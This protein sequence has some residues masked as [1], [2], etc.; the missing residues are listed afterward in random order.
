MFNK[1]LMTATLGLA[2]LAPNVTPA[3][4]QN[5]KR[6]EI[7]ILS[8][9]D[10]DLIGTV[11]PGGTLTLAPGQVVRLRMSG[12]ADRGAPRYPSAR[13]EVI[14]GAAR[15]TVRNQNEEVGNFTIQGTNAN[16]R[17][18]T[19]ISYEV[20]GRDDIAPGLRTGTI[21]VEIGRA[22][23]V[24]NNSGSGGSVT[25]FRGVILYEGPGFRGNSQALEVAQLKTLQGL[26]GA[27]SIRVQ[28]GCQAV[29]FSSPN[30]GGASI[31]TTRD[32]DDLTRSR[33]G[34][35]AYS[36]KLDCSVRDGITPGSNQSSRGVTLFKDDNFRGAQHTYVQDEP[37]LHRTV[38]G[39]DW[40]S[41]LRIDP[42]CE[43][44][45]YRDKNY[46]GDFSVVDRD[47]PDLGR[48]KVGNDSVSSLTLRCN[49]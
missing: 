8:V 34:R 22:M 46:G 37:D 40:A 1:T 47:I 2:L 12:I 19:V 26:N 41:S 36:M 31:T 16:S 17:E 6:I 4:A 25:D 7:N 11:A 48:I 3:A 35:S 44:I 43:V 5:I 21:N 38:Q 15:I 13:Y 42:G 27:G 28:D 32:V 49:R 14:S 18:R 20:L 23:P 30:F 33:L 45:L 39:G 9:P 24:P 10:L 29:L